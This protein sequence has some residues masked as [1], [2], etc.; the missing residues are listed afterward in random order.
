M[1]LV[2]RACCVPCRRLA[3][4][5]VG[6]CAVARIT[7]L[8][9]GRDIALAAGTSG[10]RRHAGLAAPVVQRPQH[11]RPVDVALKEA[12]QHLLAYARQELRTHAWPGVALR[13]P[14][15]ARCLGV[16][17]PLQMQAHPDPAL[18]VGRR[19]GVPPARAGVPG[20]M[21]AAGR[22]PGTGWRSPTPRTPRAGLPAA[23]RWPRARAQVA[24]PAAARAPA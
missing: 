22:R 12:D 8:A 15:P 3:A 7:G 18:A 17:G 13:H 9:V 2:A 1:R 19:L 14:H 10:R 11:Q 24:R 21:A 20:A 5:E 6:L 16:G 4:T 23:L